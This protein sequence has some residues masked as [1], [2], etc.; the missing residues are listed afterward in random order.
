MSV[1]EG[2][3]MEEF[4]RPLVLGSAEYY[5]QSDSPGA[6]HLFA[7]DNSSKGSVA[8]FDARSIELH[9]VKGILVKEV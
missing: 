3:N 1:M 7:G 4:F 6:A 8:L 5:V 9:F 2:H